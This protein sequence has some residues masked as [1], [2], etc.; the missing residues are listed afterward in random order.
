MA[1]TD[2]F[3]II[4]LK[5]LT[6]KAKIPYQKVYNNIILEKYNT[7]DFNDR[8]ILSNTLL[9]EVKDIFKELG[10]SVQVKRL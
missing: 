1:N 3:K 8:T 6:E 7:L 9:E 4:N 10:Y 2:K 5:R